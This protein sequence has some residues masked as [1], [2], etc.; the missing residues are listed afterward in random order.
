MFGNCNLQYDFFLVIGCCDVNSY[1]TKLFL[2]RVPLQECWR[3][4]AQKLVKTGGLATSAT[5]NILSGENQYY[6]NVYRRHEFL[7]LF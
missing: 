3:L 2:S 7:C 4:V 6:V 5:N 1:I